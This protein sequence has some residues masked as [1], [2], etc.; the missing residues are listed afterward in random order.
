[1]VKFYDLHNNGKSTGMMYAC[2][3][4]EFLGELPVRTDIEVLP[5]DE[6]RQLKIGWSVYETIGLSIINMRGLTSL[7]TRGSKQRI[8]KCF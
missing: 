5:A 4:P 7:T 1:M 2:E 3:D 8:Y 6:P